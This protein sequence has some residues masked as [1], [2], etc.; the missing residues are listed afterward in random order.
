MDFKTAFLNGELDSVIYME[1][2]EGYIN[3]LKPNMVCKLEK[4]L[5]GLK[6]SARGWNLSIDRYLK[7]SGYSQSDAD[8]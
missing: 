3:K 5:Y 2:P 8:L 1:Q 6:Q 7:D 4:S